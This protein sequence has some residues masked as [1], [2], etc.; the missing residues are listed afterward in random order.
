M[1]EQQNIE[2]ETTGLAGDIV[3]SIMTPGY[4][5]NG[6]INI[7]FY[8]FYALFA[9]LLFMIFMT[10]GNPH[11]IALLLLAICLFVSI[12]W[13]ITEMEHAKRQQ[14]KTD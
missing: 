5:A 8:T 4:T 2:I 7:M 13:F 14:Q 11:V 10:G 6:V 1:A 12:R 9:T 3:K